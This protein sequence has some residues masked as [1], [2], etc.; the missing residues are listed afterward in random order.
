[1]FIFHFAEFSALSQSFPFSFYAATA[2][3]LFALILRSIVRFVGHVQHTHLLDLRADRLA[4]R[5]TH[6]YFG[7]FPAKVTQMELKFSIPSTTWGLLK[8]LA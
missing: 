5:S 6:S 1:L 3:L 4:A 7:S 8:I 2:S